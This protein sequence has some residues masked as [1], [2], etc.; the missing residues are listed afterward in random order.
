M[1]LIC[2]KEM[3]GAIWS[4]CSLV[5]CSLIACFASL[6]SFYGHISSSGTNEEAK[7]DHHQSK[8]ENLLSGSKVLYLLSTDCLK[9]LK[10]L[11]RVWSFCHISV[12]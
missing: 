6:F 11:A 1:M 8:E 2:Q 10:L 12:R 4:F 3:V 9:S 5:F 7:E